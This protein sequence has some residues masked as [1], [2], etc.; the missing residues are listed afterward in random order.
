MKALKNFQPLAAVL[1]YGAAVFVLHNGAFYIFEK[2]D[3]KFHY[4]LCELYGFFLLCS[5]II[6]SILIF[7]KRKNIDNVGYAFLLLTCL[8]MGLAYML[9]RPILN[10]AGPE[11]ELEKA[12]FFIVFSVFLAIET[13][14]T[15]RLLNKNQ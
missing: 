1:I 13:L 15:I 12:T 14:S 8:K 9:L 4:C 7:I 6:I 5:I 10:E 11:I 3:A 2:T